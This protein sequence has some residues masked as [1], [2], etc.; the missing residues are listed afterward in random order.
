MEKPLWKNSNSYIR[1]CKDFKTYGS[2]YIYH[3]HEIFQM[4]ELEI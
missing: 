2:I 4:Y 3:I 1:T